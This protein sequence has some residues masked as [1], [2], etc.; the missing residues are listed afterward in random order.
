MLTVGVSVNTIQ[1]GISRFAENYVTQD[2]L[3]GAMLCQP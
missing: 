1:V 2:K 3:Y